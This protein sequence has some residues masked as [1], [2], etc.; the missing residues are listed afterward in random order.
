MRWRA[1]LSNAAR[2]RGVIATLWAMRTRVRLVGTV[3]ATVLCSGCGLAWIPLV[4]E[5]PPPAP[6]PTYQEPPP[7]PT[8]PPAPT[9][10]IEPYSGKVAKAAK[11]VTLDK[12]ELSFFEQM[13]QVGGAITFPRGVRVRSNDEWWAVAIATQVHANSSGYTE[14]NVEPVAYFISTRPSMEEGGWEDVTQA[15]AG[16]SSKAMEKAAA[17]LKK[18]PVPKPTPPP[19]S[20]ETYTGKRAKGAGCKAVPAAMLSKLEE[21]G[22]VGGAITYPR[23]QMVRANGKW[24]TVAVATQVNKNNAGLSPGD[25]PKT[26]MF[27][28]N[29]P[30]YKASSD[31][32]IVYFPLKPTKRD[33]AAARA[34]KCVEAG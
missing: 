26:A 18:L 14:D 20:P 10:E 16:A 6:P 27:V 13:G 8:P 12:A 22:Q 31:A 3:L 33:T 11:C 5:D 15:G 28:T 1:G 29:D 4:R 2:G 21:V 30:S 24:W 7:T 23:G 34:L 19:G 9:P 17:C 32:K 25:I